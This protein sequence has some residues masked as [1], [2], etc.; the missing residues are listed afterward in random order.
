M[1]ALF[2][3]LVSLSI[4]VCSAQ[5]ITISKEEYTMLTF[6]IDPYASFKE[7]GLDIVAEFTLVS[8]F[9]YVKVSGQAFPKLTGGY[10]DLTGGAGFN[11]QSAIFG[12]ETRLYE[13]I[14]L[15]HNWRGATEEYPA[16]DGP[17]FGIDL[18]IDFKI[19]NSFLIGGRITTDWREDMKYSGADPKWVPSFFI[20]STVKL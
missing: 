15:G 11:Q 18:G 3:L 16:Y 19:S 6:G 4:T 14:R 7:E 5:W 12:V 9:G 1:K 8:H 13:G 17:L 10:Y 2:I 20:T